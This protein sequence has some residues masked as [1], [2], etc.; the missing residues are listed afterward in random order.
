[1]GEGPLS[2]PP[3]QSKYLLLNHLR[4]GV[5]LRSRGPLPAFGASPFSGY[6]NLEEQI[7]TRPSS[8]G[9]T[10]RWHQTKPGFP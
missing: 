7:L 6:L 5:H 10:V 3:P 1:M 4:T 9:H 8:P 2:L